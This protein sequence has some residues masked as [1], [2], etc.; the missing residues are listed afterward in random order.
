[1]TSAPSVTQG[2][3]IP[4]EGMSARNRDCFCGKLTSAIAMEYTQGPF[5]PF[6]NSPTSSGFDKESELSSHRPSSPILEASDPAVPSSSQNPAR[7]YHTDNPGY[8]HVGYRRSDGTDVW[9]STPP[10]SSYFLQIFRNHKLQKMSEKDLDIDWHDEFKLASFPESTTRKQVAARRLRLNEIICA[11]RNNDTTTI[12]ESPA[13]EDSTPLSRDAKSSHDG[14]GSIETAGTTRDPPFDTMLLVSA[15]NHPEYAPFYVLNVHLMNHWTIA[16]LFES[17]F[18][19]FRKQGQ[20]AES[21]STIEATFLW[22]GSTLLLS[23]DRQEDWIVFW[24]ILRT[25]WIEKR[26][27]FEE[28]DCEIKMVLRAE[29]DA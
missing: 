24:N 18:D 14:Q 29:E 2:S 1:M 19:E 17:L 23:K 22:N 13:L 3:T 26:T 8:L 16:H 10:G 5:H 9:L 20:P 7:K 6:P 21:A 28:N 12:D 4:A 15:T 11:N 27:Y 25:A